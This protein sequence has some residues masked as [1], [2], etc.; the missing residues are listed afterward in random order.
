MDQGLVG[1]ACQSLEACWETS[2]LRLKPFRPYQQV[3]ATI[4]NL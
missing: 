1:Y 3:T 2:A 4:I